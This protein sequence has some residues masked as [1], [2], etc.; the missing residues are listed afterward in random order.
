MMLEVLRLLNM[1]KTVVMLK[2]SEEKQ[3]N[4]PAEKSANSFSFSTKQ[5]ML[6]EPIYV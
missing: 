6:K 1:V 4:S 5:R 2:F 3:T